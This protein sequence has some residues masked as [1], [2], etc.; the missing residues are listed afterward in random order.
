MNLHCGSARKSKFTQEEIKSNPGRRNYAIKKAV[1]AS[2]HQGHFKYGESAGMQCTSNAYISIVF[3]IIKNIN[4]WKS[5]DL[6]YILKEVYI[7]N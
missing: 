1:Q 6:D 7:L 5:L 2:H 3:S 4:L